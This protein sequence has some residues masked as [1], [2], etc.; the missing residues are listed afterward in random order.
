MEALQI[1]F[2]TDGDKYLT[3]EDA[4]WAEFGIWQDADSD[5]KTDDGEFKSLDEMGVLSIRLYK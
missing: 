2:D 5:G 1:A 3:P 4:R